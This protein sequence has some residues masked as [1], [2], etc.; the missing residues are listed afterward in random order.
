MRDAKF[1]WV[2]ERGELSYKR[3]NK[4][5]KL[6]SR[7]SPSFWVELELFDNFPK[8]ALLRLRS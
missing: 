7:L 6:D 4:Y 1:K 2:L 8:I 3:R 5:D